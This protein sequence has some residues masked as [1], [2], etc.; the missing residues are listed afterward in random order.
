MRLRRFGMALVSAAGATALATC[1]AF[2][3]GSTYQLGSGNHV[4]SGGL[5]WLNRSVTVQGSV[6]DIGGAGTQVEFDAYAN[7][8]VVDYQTRSAVNETTPYNFTIDGSQWPGGITKVF[9]I[10]WDVHTGEPIDH[11]TLVRS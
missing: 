7:T 3:A 4:A 1:P 11:A 10:L 5:T 6:G 8:T 2:A 9:V